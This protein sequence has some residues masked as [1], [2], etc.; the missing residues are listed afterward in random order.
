MEQ[1]TRW[2][3]SVSLKHDQKMFLALWLWILFLN[4]KLVIALASLLLETWKKT[5]TL[6][7]RRKKL[8]MT[9]FCRW[10]ERSCKINY[11]FFNYSSQCLSL[12]NFN[13]SFFLFKECRITSKLLFSLR[14][15]HNSLSVAPHKKR[16]HQLSYLFHSSHILIH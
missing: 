9:I 6:M 5:R 7:W 3:P 15:E 12:H 2:K 1:R 13:Y 10:W 8:S 11:I 14:K 16:S 4:L